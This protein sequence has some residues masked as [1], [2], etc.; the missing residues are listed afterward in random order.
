VAYRLKCTPFTR[1]IQCNWP[2]TT[3]TKQWL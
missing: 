2:R 3:E 1:A